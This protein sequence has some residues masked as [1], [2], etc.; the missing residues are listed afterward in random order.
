MKPV[1]QHFVVEGYF[2]NKHFSIGLLG[3]NEA[4]IRNQMALYCDP[5]LIIER[6]YLHV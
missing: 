4:D 3:E 6:I 2:E 1:K 5:R